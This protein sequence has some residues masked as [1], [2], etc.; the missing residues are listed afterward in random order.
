MEVRKEPNI[1]VVNILVL[2]VI[3]LH[4]AYNVNCKNSQTVQKYKKQDADVHHSIFLTS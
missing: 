4:L 1:L 2:I 3:F